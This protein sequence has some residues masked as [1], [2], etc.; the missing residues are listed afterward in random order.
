MDKK[1]EIRRRSIQYITDRY[2]KSFCIVV[3]TRLLHDRSLKVRDFAA[4]RIA[5]LNL[6]EMMP[7]LEIAMQSETDPDTQR[8][9]SQVFHL[10]RDG[11]FFDDR[12]EHKTLWLYFPDLFPAATPWVLDAQNRWEKGDSIEVIK[13]ETLKAN[14]EINLLRREWEWPTE[15][16]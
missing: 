12:P 11:C 3:L 14:P 7:V 6:R 9:M 4:S 8:D 16:D 5:Y 13:S 2:S 15:Q 1:A 10:M